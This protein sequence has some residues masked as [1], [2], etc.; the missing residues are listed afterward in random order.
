MA[1]PWRAHGWGWRGAGGGSQPGGREE[2]ALVRLGDRLF[3]ATRWPLT[4]RLPA[5][6]PSAGAL[7]GRWQDRPSLLAGPQRHLRPTHS[8]AQPRSGVSALFPEAFS[9]RL[10]ASPAQ[11]C[12][13]AAPS[14]HL[15]CQPLSV[16]QWDLESPALGSSQLVTVSLSQD[17]AE[18]SLLICKVGM[19]VPSSGQDEV[20]EHLLV[21]WVSV[22]WTGQ[23]SANCR[24]C[25]RAG[26]WSPA[27]WR[28]WVSGA[29]APPAGPV[30]AHR[31]PAVLR[32]GGP[33]RLQT[34]L[35]PV[36]Q[37][38]GQRLQPQP[39]PAFPEP[40]RPEVREAKPC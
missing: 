17:L 5:P 35:L 37:T 27:G 24:D 16:A 39:H 38:S 12:G 7:R 22:P 1:P 40:C 4:R 10:R 2:G 13:A 8:P 11:P 26:P 18:P 6:F 21:P 9:A 34:H 15:A 33:Q 31:T 29:A 14:P 36:P 28:R 25:G 19:R 32:A 30:A 3:S 23:A 20:L